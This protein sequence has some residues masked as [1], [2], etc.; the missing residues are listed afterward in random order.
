MTKKR[1][2]LT[3]NRII[4]ASI[5]FGLLVASGIATKRYFDVESEWI[6][7]WGNVV[8][9]MVGAIATIVVL[10]EQFRRDDRDKRE[11]LHGNLNFVVDRIENFLFDSHNIIDHALFHKDLKTGVMQLRKEYE[12][13]LENYNRS[14]AVLITDRYVYNII[15]LTLV[16]CKDL[17]DF[18][19]ASVLEEKEIVERAV[20]ECQYKVRRAITQ[21]RINIGK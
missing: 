8:G 7:F 5:I 4:G 20:E 9:G 2:W 12:G 15:E 3:R 6:G 18:F 13:L 16:W 11:D 1:T 10:Q 21:L 19:E 14:H 17:I